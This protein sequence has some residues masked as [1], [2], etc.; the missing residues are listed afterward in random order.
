MPE[1]RFDPV[2][3]AQVDAGGRLLDRQELRRISPAMDRELARQAGA[4]SPI[5]RIARQGTRFTYAELG[6]S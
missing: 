3:H 2:A 5:A 6:D 1:T 4:C